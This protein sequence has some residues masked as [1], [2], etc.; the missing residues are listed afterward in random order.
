MYRGNV[1][2]L[3]APPSNGAAK[4]LHPSAHW[5]KCSHLCML[6]SRPN[7]FSGLGVRRRPRTQENKTL[8]GPPETKNEYFLSYFSKLYNSMA[9]DTSIPT[10]REVRDKCEFPRQE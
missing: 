9:S 5:L 7:L 2:I 8:V 10:W 1:A 6:V 3:A 4:P